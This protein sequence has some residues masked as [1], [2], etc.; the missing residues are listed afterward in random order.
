MTL[1]VIPARGGSKRIP[2]KNIRPFLGKPMI[3]W[4][5][6]AALESGLFDHVIV[7]TDDEEIAATA[8]AAGAEVPFMRPPELADDYTGIAEV[9]KHALQWAE[10][11]SISYKSA[12]CIYATAVFTKPKDLIHSKDILDSSD[13][14]YVIS[15][16]KIYLPLHR[17]LVLTDNGGIEM[18]FPQ[19]KYNRTQD[20]PDVYYD[21][22]QFCWGRKKAWLEMIPD[23]SDFST[24]YIIKRRVMDIDTMEDWKLAEMLLQDKLSSAKLT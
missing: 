12:C 22:G 17:A 2:R 7:S 4:P 15:L 9:M 16:S 21:P 6:E 19:Y 24:P 18:L 23:F 8:R 3:A 14:N 11:Q 5:I 13:S 10:T 20:L 1:C